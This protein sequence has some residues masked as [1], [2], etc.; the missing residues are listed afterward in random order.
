[1]IY[2]CTHLDTNS[3]RLSCRVSARW[4]FKLGLEVDAACE[5]LGVFSGAAVFPGADFEPFLAE[6]FAF[7][8]P[9]VWAESLSSLN[10]PFRIASNSNGVGGAR[11]FH[12]S[13]IES[14]LRISEWNTFSNARFAASDSPDSVVVRNNDRT[15]L[16]A[17]ASFRRVA[18]SCAVKFTS[19]S[20][21]RH[22]N[23]R[24]DRHVPFSPC[25]SASSSSPQSLRLLQKVG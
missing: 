5:S 11:D 20:T 10:V 3:S 16:N 23:L 8:V 24:C 12:M 6:P 15:T 22:T 9:F 14:K 17:W 13:A 7:E 25:F 19:V 2:D 21:F 1:M 4:S 18:I